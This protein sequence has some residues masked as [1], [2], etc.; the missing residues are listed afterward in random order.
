MASRDYAT[1][2]GSLLVAKASRPSRLGIDTWVRFGALILLN[3][4]VMLQSGSY[5]LAPGGFVNPGCR[6]I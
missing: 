1:Q 5:G 4:P 6:F 3:V 2:L